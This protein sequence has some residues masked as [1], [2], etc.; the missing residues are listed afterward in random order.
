MTGY[1]FRHPWV[2]FFAVLAAFGPLSARAELIVPTWDFEGGTLTGW[3]TGD[4][5][6]TNGL[7]TFGVASGTSHGRAAWCAL[8]PGTNSDTDL[9]NGKL[10]HHYA[11][12]MVTYLQTTVSLGGYRNCELKFDYHLS[13]EN[14]TCRFQIF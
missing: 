6:S 13:C 8:S 4:R 2:V 5:N 1:L 12:D 3:S 9:T 14:N 7:D 10:W 11:N